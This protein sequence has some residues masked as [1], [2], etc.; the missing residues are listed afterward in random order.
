MKSILNNLGN[1]AKTVGTRIADTA[2]YVARRPVQAIATIATAYTMGCAPTVIYQ[3]EYVPY[4]VPAPVPSQ[5]NYNETNVQ[6]L[7]SNNKV[8]VGTIQGNLKAK[9]EVDAL[10]VPVV[11]ETVVVRKEKGKPGTDY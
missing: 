2:K 7:G 9:V 4:P 11:P 3:R 8:G 10:T 1:V 6:V 5:V